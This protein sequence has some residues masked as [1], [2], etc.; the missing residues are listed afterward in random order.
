M[1][2]SPKHKGSVLIFTIHRVEPWWAEVGRSL[3]FEQS[4]TVSDI[5]GDGTYCLADDFY[6]AYPSRLKGAGPTHFSNEEITDIIAR[7]RLLRWL[8]EGQAK[9]M[10]LAMADAQ[11]KVLDDAKP[12]LVTAFPMDRY[13]SD[14][15]E[16]L[17][18]ARGVPFYEL[19]A[20]AVPGMS[21][22]M[23]RGQLVTTRESP[24]PAL[25]EKVID[26]IAD[27]LFAPAYVEGVNSFTR[28]RW[29]KTFAYFRLRGLYFRAYSMLIK[30]PMSSHYLDAQSF[31][32][33]K[34]LLSDVGICG[35]VDRQW[36]S[37]MSDFPKE[38]RLFMGLQLFPEASID[39]WIANRELIAHDDLLE[40]VARR[41]SDA[42]YCIAIKDHPLQFGFRRTDLIRRLLAIPNT[43]FV[44]YDVSGNVV[45][46][47]CGVNFTCTGTLGMQA[48]LTGKVSIATPCYYTTQEDFVLFS[49]LSDVDTLPERVA[50]FKQP[51]LRDSQRRIVSHLLQGS[52]ESN[53][54]SFKGF[55]PSAPD[56]AVS[57]LGRAF[58]KFLHSLEA[59]R[60]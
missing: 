41:F 53:F 56:P 58:G 18:V 17:C 28:L 50:M 51:P 59:G 3:G 2:D 60:T 31:L 10:I 34:P 24:D 35:M 55:N 30:D 22:L 37:K 43:V 5:R 15:L 12:A 47:Y 6:A 13:V 27:P 52:F 36:K 44:P 49:D 11:V 21:M 4:F 7:C 42:G 33:H 54:F 45:L 40:R 26:E 29:L 16:R 9:A 38:K 46:D 32:G 25:V 57:E 14:V 39:Y 1:I 23:I 19:T 20:S 8:P 48:A